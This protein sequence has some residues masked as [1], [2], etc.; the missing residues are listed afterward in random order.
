MSTFLMHLARAVTNDSFHH[1]P[2]VNTAQGEKSKYCQKLEPENVEKI[3]LLTVHF[4]S[5]D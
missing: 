2:W 4:L 5:T 1:Y 3:K